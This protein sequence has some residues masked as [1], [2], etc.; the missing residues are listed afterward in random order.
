MKFHF[1]FATHLFKY[2]NLVCSPLLCY[3]LGCNNLCLNLRRTQFH[4]NFKTVWCSECLGISSQAE[5]Y[6]LFA[7]SRVQTTGCIRVNQSSPQ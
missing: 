5:L 1:I 6:T 4:T 7:F 3:F 2:L